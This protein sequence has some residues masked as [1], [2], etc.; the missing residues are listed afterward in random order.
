[1]LS[2]D[3]DQASTTLLY[4][5][6]L[7][8]QAII[9]L[10]LELFREIARRLD[11]LP[12]RLRYRHI[13]LAEEDAGLERMIEANADA[14]MRSQKMTVSFLSAMAVDPDRSSRK[15]RASSSSG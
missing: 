13:V 6:P 4:F 9:V 12:L 10:L 3:F 2:V 14:L 5:S 8:D 11:D 7:G 15:F 1:M